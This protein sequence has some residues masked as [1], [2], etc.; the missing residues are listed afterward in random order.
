[1]NDFLITNIVAGN[2]TLCPDTTNIGCCEIRSSQSDTPQEKE[3]L[4]K[5]LKSNNESVNLQI[6][7]RIST[8]VSADTREEAIEF[9]INEFVT[10][11]DVWGMYQPIPSQNFYLCRAGFSLDLCDN[12]YCEHTHPQDINGLMFRRSTSAITPIT[13]A[14]IASVKNDELGLRFKRFCH[15]FH[16]ANMEKNPQ[17][18]LIFLWFALEAMVRKP[19]RNSG[20]GHSD[21]IIP[22]ILSTL[23]MQ[24][25]NATDGDYFCALSTIDG[26]SCS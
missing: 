26:Y 7:M 11:L 2:V 8:I 6:S 5:S 1:M 22:Y 13:F 19:D 24:R 23:G 16:N 4:K 10:A 3:L 21:N 14:Q 15:W 25:G 12:S 18:K 20:R 9:A 17:I